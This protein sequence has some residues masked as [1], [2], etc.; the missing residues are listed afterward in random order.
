MK[1]LITYTLAATL[2][3][4]ATAHQNH[5][6]HHH[7]RQ[8]GSKVEKRGPDVVTEVVV[9]ATETVYELKGKKVGKAFA[10]KGIKG[11]KYVVVG[12]S[13]PSYVPPPP[14]PAPSTTK[15][16]VKTTTE[17]AKATLGAQFKE[18]KPVAKPTTT[19]VETPAYEE[20]TTVV[21]PK[22]KAPK[23]AIASADTG[24]SYSTSGGQG[25]DSIFPSGEVDCSEFPSDYG[26]VKLD[27]LGFGG[28]SGLQQVPDYTS[29]STSIFTIHTG[30]SGDKCK[31]GTMCSYACPPGYQKTQWPKAQGS[32]KESVGGLF[33][34]KQGKL[35]LTRT[36]F[37]TLCEAGVGGVTIQNDLDEI[38]STCRTDYPGTEAMVI[39]A[40]AQPGASVSVCNPN[41]SKYYQWDNS[42]TS[43]QYYVNKKGYGNEAA[44]VWNSKKDASGAGNWSPIIL[45]VGQGPDG[46][47]YISVFQNL[48]TSDALLDFNIEITGDVNS[49][50]G[51]KV[52]SGFIGGSDGCT[53]A[54]SSGGKAVIRYY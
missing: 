25:I 34:N 54:M 6:Q 51:Y 45:G 44:C 46:N 31:P 41:Q 28:W 24:D 53:T 49:K 15:E 32:K 19:A 10:E 3:A 2:V 12:E 33:C 7:R 18:K 36:T 52:G 16:E 8:A 23:V 35:E 37:K 47:T 38:V 29:G 13:E 5:H 4:G 22:T 26:A 21:K 50:C 39:P 43:A 40:I 14:P 1:N 48:P 9:A 20:P 30:I 27:W 11:G 17:A 42:G